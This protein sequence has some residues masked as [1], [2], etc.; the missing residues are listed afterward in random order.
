MALKDMLGVDP[1]FPPAERAEYARQAEIAETIAK[2]DEIAK[3]MRQFDKALAFGVAAAMGG[4]KYVRV[5]DNGVRGRGGYQGLLSVRYVPFVVDEAAVAQA[6]ADALLLARYEA[7]QHDSARH[8]PPLTPLS[9]AERERASVLW[10][11]RVSAK[12]VADKAARDARAPRV[13]CQG[14]WA[15]EDENL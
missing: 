8:G 3:G 14:D 13:I 4:E 1:A 9:V 7:M 5:P 6:E 11:A 12:V 2:R 15:D 10:S